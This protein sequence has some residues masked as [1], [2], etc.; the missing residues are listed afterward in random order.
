ME[1]NERTKIGLFTVLGTAP[2]VLGGIFWLT[3]IYFN[4]NTALADN[5]KQDAK[6]QD[7]MNILLDIRDRVIR[8]E[9]ATKTT[10]EQK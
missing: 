1:I 6:I 3:A 9:E 2:F 10:K 8:I 7:Q 4:V 5:V